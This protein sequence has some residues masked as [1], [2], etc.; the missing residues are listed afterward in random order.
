G[1]LRECLLDNAVESV[2]TIGRSG[3]GQKHP[4]LRELELRDLTD[5][6]AHSAELTGQDA[7]FFCLGVTSA[8]MTE[9]DYRRMTYDFAVSAARALVAASP[10]MTFVFVSGAGTDPSSKTMWARVKGQAENAILELPFR[11][12]YVFRPALVRPMHG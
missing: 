6:S 7:C 5:Y 11:G 2:L 9:A 1:V 4:K 10:A 12:K 3:T 8:G